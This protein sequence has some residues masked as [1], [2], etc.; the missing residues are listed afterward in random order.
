MHPKAAASATE[1]RYEPLHGVHPL[2]GATIEVFY[3]DRVFA[4]MGGKGWFWWVCNPD[5]VP[6]WP[7]HGP[8]ASSDRAYHDALTSRSVCIDGDETQP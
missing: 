2:T 4:S 3:A 8:F 7:P 1:R 5:C 6:D